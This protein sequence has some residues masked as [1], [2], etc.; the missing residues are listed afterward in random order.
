MTAAHQ[1]AVPTKWLTSARTSHDAQGVGASRSPGRTL[2]KMARVLWRAWF[3]GHS[4]TCGP[5][6]RDPP[7][8]RKTRREE[9]RN[10]PNA[11]TPGSLA[12]SLGSDPTAEP[13]RTGAAFPRRRTTRPRAKTGRR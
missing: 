4:L 5:L 8:P 11:M 7:T 2:F 13:L 1:R 6:V 10:R 12:E 3:S 9:E